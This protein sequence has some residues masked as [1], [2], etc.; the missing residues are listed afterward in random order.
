MRR[1]IM[2]GISKKVA[3]GL[4][5][6]VALF[7]G[8]LVLSSLRPQEATGQDKAEDKSPARAALP[9]KEELP[10]FDK[11][12]V[13][14]LPKGKKMFNAVR[15]SDKLAIRIT[16][17]VFATEAEA[18]KETHDWVYNWHAIRMLTGSPSGRKIGQE[19]WHTYRNGKDNMSII[20][21]DGRSAVEVLISLPVP[22]DAKGKPILKNGNPI[23]GSLK[24]AD[25]KLAEDQVIKALGKLEKKGL[26]SKKA[27]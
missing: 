17:V 16:T 5:S 3:F 13:I 20:V 24:E 15:R 4:L 22:R 18:Q 21:L 7:V 23:R 26:T 14:A 2:F 6:A 1:E 8:F 12:R 10:E 9:T 11:H 25:L 19:S 27:S